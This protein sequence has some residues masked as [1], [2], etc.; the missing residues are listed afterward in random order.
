MKFMVSFTGSPLLPSLPVLPAEQ[1]RQ[2]RLG[3]HLQPLR[4]A[5]Q[6]HPAFPPQTQGDSCLPAPRYCWLLFDADGT[7]FD[8]DRAERAALEQALAQIGV[9]FDASHL[10]TY[11]RINQAL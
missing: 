9:S 1:V 2:T 10:A 5:P 11:R 6:S 8:Y 4:D 7:L 3:S